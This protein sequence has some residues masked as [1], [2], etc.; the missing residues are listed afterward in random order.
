MSNF[1]LLDL[2]KSYFSTEIID[3]ASNHLGESQSGITKI[4][5]AAIPTL[6]GTIADKAT[7]SP[8]STNAVM[9]MANEQNESGITNQLSNFLGG[10][11]GNDLFSKSSAIIKSLFGNDGDSNMLTNLLS[12]FSGTKGS[13]V[14]AIVSMAAPALLGLIGKFAKDNDT[15]NNGLTTMLKEQKQIAMSALPAGFSLASLTGHTNTPVSHATA[16]ATS[17]DY[18]EMEEKT[19]G[20]G[21]LILPF[22]IL[23]AIAVG[24][25]YL[26]RNGC[27]N[28]V[29]ATTEHGGDSNHTAAGHTTIK[30]TTANF[31]KAVNGAMDTLTGDFNYNEGDITTI[32]LPN[33]GGELKVG[34]LS[35]EAKLIAFLN[36][37][38]EAI[39]TVKG[40]WFEFTNVHFKSGGAELTDASATQLKNMVAI[41]KA[42][43]TATFK[44]GGYTDN[45]GNAAK[46][47]TLSQKR[48]QAVS[49]MAV[50]LGAPKA[51]FTEAKGYGDQFAIGDNSSPEGRAMNRRVAVNVK[52]K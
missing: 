45:T 44:F 50:N 3:K 10:E 46:N 18:K 52:S 33:N 49:A 38:N 15:D 25:L 30:D 31:V 7:S 13:S 20:M 8:D 28:K 6:I 36:D 11:G 1:N 26:F 34:A 37:K 16:T 32:T 9:Q 21:K 41:A 35:T 23:V 48:A 12:N 19:G 43:P 27:N 29:A 5:S 42:Y 24:C 51:S 47:L 4:I 2:A 17:H 14:G 22:L 39:D 40:N